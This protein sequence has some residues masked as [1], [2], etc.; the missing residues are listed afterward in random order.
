[1]WSDPVEAADGRC[2]GQYRYN[3]VRGCSYFFGYELA[4][5]FLEKN[6]LLSIFRAHEAQLEGYKMYMWKG[7][8]DFPTIITIFSAPNYCDVYNNKGA[9]IK[10]VVIL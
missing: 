9:I 6:R 1:M 8:K 5:T 3:E 10:F 7:A 4:K 2:E